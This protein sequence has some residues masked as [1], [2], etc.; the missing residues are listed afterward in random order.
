MSWAIL[1]SARS[2]RLSSVGI[3]VT[4]QVGRDHVKWAATRALYAVPAPAIAP[5]VDQQERRRACV[6]P[7]DIMQLQSVRFVEAVFRVESRLRASG[8][9]AL[10]RKARMTWLSS[11][12]P[13]PGGG[14][15]QNFSRAA[16]ASGVAARRCA[17]LHDAEILHENVDGARY[18][19]SSCNMRAGRGP[20]RLQ[21]E[22]ADPETMSSIW[23]H[24]DAELSGKL[25]KLGGGGQMHAAQELVDRPAVEPSRAG[26]RRAPPCRPSRRARRL[27]NAAS[28]AP[29]MMVSEPAVR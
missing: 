21:L 10:A 25:A 7:V 26:R 12:A 18:A 13:S 9:F 15:G 14:G 8:Y 11:F 29:T 28:L 5:A 24:V 19:G 1:L 20:E 3:A 27:P 16:C 22:A 17:G 2:C 23:S 6:S 4:A